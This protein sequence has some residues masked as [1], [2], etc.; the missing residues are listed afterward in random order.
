MLQQSTN[1]GLL[2]FY[3][4][5]VWFLPNGAII[6]WECVHWCGYG[7]Q[8]KAGCSLHAVP[9]PTWRVMLVK[10][11]R[12]SLFATNGYVLVADE[13][14]TSCE[15]SRWPGIM[16]S[17]ATVNFSARWHYVRAKFVHRCWHA[18]GR[19]VETTSAWHVCTL[20]FSHC[21]QSCSHDEVFR[22]SFTVLHVWLCSVMVTFTFCM[23][24]NPDMTRST[25]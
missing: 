4:F 17:S 12:F 18:V 13:S 16:L 9:E 11:L 25:L 15:V 24:Q 6:L 23:R 8:S 3:D 20:Y 7:S 14:V 21:K 10:C 5:G 19:T 22:D 2:C 1:V